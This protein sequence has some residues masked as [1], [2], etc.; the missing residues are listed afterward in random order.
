MVFDAYAVR[1]WLFVGVWVICVGCLKYPTTT[2]I[3]WTKTKH[4]R[5]HLVGCALSLLVTW[6]DLVCVGFAV[7]VCLTGVCFCDAFGDAQTSQRALIWSSSWCS[8]IHPPLPTSRHD[9]TSVSVACVVVLLFGTLFSCVLVIICYG[10][11]C[12]RDYCACLNWD[13]GLTITTR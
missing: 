12:K 1:G 4:R 8:I 5:C 7:L 9:T 2:T 13:S 6:N 3:S 10:G 11:F